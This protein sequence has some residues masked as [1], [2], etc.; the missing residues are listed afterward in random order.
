MASIQDVAVLAFSVADGCSKILV[1]LLCFLG[2]QSPPRSPAVDDAA[3]FLLVLLPVAYISGV[4]VT[5][6]AV[7]VL[8]YLHLA[9]PVPP[10]ASASASATAMSLADLGRFIVLVFTLVSAWLLVIAVFLALYFVFLNAVERG[11]KPGLSSNGLS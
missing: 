11:I 10:P 3:T 2:G 9:A 1:P 7:V 5:H 8:A 6:F 4:I